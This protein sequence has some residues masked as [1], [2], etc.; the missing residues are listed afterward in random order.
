MQLKVHQHFIP[1]MYLK[2]WVFDSKDMLYVVSIKF[3]NLDIYEKSYDNELFYEDY[4]YDIVNNEGDL[5]TDNKT[6]NILDEI[7]KRHDRLLN[8]MLERCDK[9]QAVLDKG[10]NRLDD[11]LNFISLLVARNPHNTPKII[12]GTAYNNNLMFEFAE[13]IKSFRNVRIN[14]VFFLEAPKG[15]SFIARDNPMTMLKQVFSIP[16]SPRYLAYIVFDKRDMPTFPPNIPYTITESDVIRFNKNHDGKP[17]CT[18]IG[19]TK[20]DL[21]NVFVKQERI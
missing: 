14:N 20:K 1:R 7:E 12:R 3:A 17:F 11:F 16:L 5:L 13:E 6:E 8:R 4:C 19:S 10:T 15:S 2:R 18:L 9:H 21:I